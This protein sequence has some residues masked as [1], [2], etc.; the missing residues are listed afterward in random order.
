MTV[1]PFFKLRPEDE[2]DK[3]DIAICGEGCKWKGKI[4]ECDEEIETEGFGWESD[5]YEV[6][7]C[8]KCGEVIS[9]YSYK[10][11]R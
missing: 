4:S 9:D 7:I 1:V 8:P 10:E 2:F 3:D 11:E 6:H 5:S